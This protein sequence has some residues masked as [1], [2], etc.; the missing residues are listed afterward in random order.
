M[1]TKDS[2]YLTNRLNELKKDYRNKAAPSQNGNHSQH[3]PFNHSQPQVPNYDERD[4]LYSN[5][6]APSKVTFEGPTDSNLF[7]YN[8]GSPVAT[9]KIDRTLYAT[10]KIQTQKAPSILID[11]K[12][13]RSTQV[14]ETMKVSDSSFN[15]IRAYPSSNIGQ[16]SHAS[17]II[18]P[19]EPRAKVIHASNSKS[20]VQNDSNPFDYRPSNFQVPPVTVN[21]EYSFRGGPTPTLRQ[22]DY[23]PSGLRGTILTHT[24]T[25]F[26]SDRNIGAEPG[27]PDV[28]RNLNQ[29]SFME[30]HEVKIL[31]E[32]H[33]KLSNQ[34]AKNN[35]LGDEILQLRRQ[36]DGEKGRVVH[37]DEQ[38][39]QEFRHAK[40]TEA[41]TIDAFQKREHQLADLTDQIAHNNDRHTHMRGE[42]EKIQVEND[43]L[44]GELKR[45]GEITSE[46]ILD[47][48]NNINSVARMKEFEVEKFVM[49]KEKA[50]NSAEFVIEQMKVH[51][52]DRSG[53]IEEQVRKIQ[54]EMD[55]TSAELKVISDELRGFN[56]TADQKINSI[57]NMVIQEEQEKHRNEA[58][59]IEVKLTTEEE[60]IGRLNRRNTDLLNK[61]QA[62]ERDGKNR[63]M[64]KKNENTR[65]KEDLSSFETNY[66]KLLIQVAN[67]NR[68]Y[69]KKKDMVELAKSD[70]EEVHN[71]SQ[72]LDHRYEEEMHNIQAGQE[73][74]LQEL[75]QQFG[76]LRERENRLNQEIRNESERIF[77]L[78]KRH[79]DLIENVQRNFNAT[80][81]SQF[82]GVGK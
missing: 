19:M 56:F 48:E 43:M 25:H 28:L 60:E 33:Q 58:R 34:I 53:K 54:V 67:E 6:K 55:R 2:E 26:P 13:P 69:E 27:E 22:T 45:L 71:K 23:A 49:E 36:M 8:A 17:G 5:F 64:A 24:Q 16:A 63:I 46:K 32:M 35:K 59:E 50:N 38:L 44:R 31:D 20:F 76:N 62:T 81:E 3:P 79:N 40:A 77:A 65:L 4:V 21:T 10:S 82:A 12:R 41:E 9:S 73:E 11:S 1:A 78:Q 18:N 39:K 30:K 42:L 47:L 29:A 15:G 51:F 57:M 68:E 14:Y 7:A 37:L 66:N 61:L 75:E 74:T 72:M 80:L 52:N 70:Y